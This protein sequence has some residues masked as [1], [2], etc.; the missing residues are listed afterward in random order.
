M[1][2]FT[3]YLSL[4][5]AILMLASC[6]VACGG[7]EKK[8]ETKKPTGGEETPG[9]LV[10]DIPESI[11]DLDLKGE[12]INFVV[13]GGDED[14]EDDSMQ[15]R[16]IAPFDEEDLSYAV[17]S[18]LVDRN[19][20]VENLLNV[21]INL[22]KV[23][24]MQALAT[25]LGETLFIGLAEY[26]VVAGYQYFDVGLT[27]GENAGMFLNYNTMTEEENRINIDADYWD[28]NL[29]DI[30]TYKDCSFWVTGDLSQN[31]VGCVTVS[32]VNKTLWDRYSAKIAEI[33]AAKG[34]TDIYEIVDQKL[35]TI[36]LV[37]EIS[38]AIYVDNNSN[39]KIDLGDTVGF[40]SYTPSLNTIMTDV[41]AAGAGI[42]YSS[43]NDEGVP[44]IDFYNQR[45][46]LFANK[47]LKLYTESN[48]LLIAWQDKY[49]VELFGEGNI[50]MTPNYMYQAEFDLTEMTDTY[51][52]LPAPLLMAGEN[53]TSCLGDSV[54]Q[55]GIPYTTKEEGKLTAATA[56][57]EAMAFYSKKMVTP[58][59]YDQ[60]LKGRYTHVEA[61]DRQGEMIDMIRNSTFSDFAM[62]W[63][64]SI[65]NLTWFFRQS[66]TDRKLASKVAAQESSWTTNLATLLEE[67]EGSQW[68]QM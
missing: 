28:K 58:V 27:V 41:L 60:M 40:I 17:N 36:D 3:K 19:R 9:G 32:F 22:K 6:L 33:P 35:W 26:D 11:R 51:V 14:M 54:S 53:Y 23:T 44:E 5:L 7:G 4:A 46:S 39:E 37:S 34:L 13:C 45:T 1:S 66:C 52:V 62:I 65:G 48:A 2:K 42:T 57:L 56:T 29:Y 18:A 68:N 31:W 25:H 61:G 8:N 21:E 50:L 38:K 10:S 12:T 16:S 59:Y 20:E 47:L 30:M 55:Y 24:G 49:I 67:I 43:L 63:S 15:S 64:N